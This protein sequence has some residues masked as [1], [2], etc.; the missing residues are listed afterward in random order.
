MSS[1]AASAW[2]C[3]IGRGEPET[4]PYP[5][6]RV[7]LDPSL[8]GPLLLSSFTLCLCPAAVRFN[9][10]RAWRPERGPRPMPPF[11]PRPTDEVVVAGCCRLYSRLVHIDAPFAAWNIA[12]QY[13]LS[14]TRIPF[15]IRPRD[16]RP[17]DNLLPAVG[18][19]GLSCRFWNL[20]SQWVRRHWVVVARGQRGLFHTL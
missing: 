14:R 19:L 20:C 1:V 9:H 15:G 2:N 17:V 11:Q 5:C 6:P 8:R 7:A 4:H 12:W 16:L 10:C 18:A 13:I 3:G